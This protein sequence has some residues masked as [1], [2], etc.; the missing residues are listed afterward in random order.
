L[1]WQLYEL[2]GHGINGVEPD[3]ESRQAIAEFGEQNGP[4]L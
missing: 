2:R 1:K 3:A 4:F